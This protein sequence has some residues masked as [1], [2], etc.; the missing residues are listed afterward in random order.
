MS[1]NR[2]RMTTEERRA[3]RQGLID[4]GFRREAVSM[5]DGEGR[6]RETFSRETNVVTVEWG[7]KAP[8]KRV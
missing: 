1:K 2:Q 4:L 8:E 3:L 5:D 6:Y 7:P